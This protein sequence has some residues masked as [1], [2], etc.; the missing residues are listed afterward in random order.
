M[1]TAVPASYPDLFR[2]VAKT[3]ANREAILTP[4]ESVTYSEL[5]QLSDRLAS[6]LGPHIANRPVLTFF[7]RS[8]ECYIS[9]IAI[10]KAGGF[11]VPVNGNDP[12]ERI[13][14]IV[15]DS[16]AV[17][18][19]TG[20]D[21][22]LPASGSLPIER[23]GLEQLRELPSAEPVQATP[24]GLDFAYMIYTSGS[25]GKPK[26]VPIHHSALLNHN[27]WCVNEFE[28]KETTRVMQISS[29]SFDFSIE[30]IFP[31][32]LAGGSLFVPSD[33]SLQD[34]ATF[35]RTVEQY[36]V[37]SLS[38][39]TAF[40]HE[41]VIALDT[42]PFPRCVNDVG[43]GGE[44]VNPR[45]VQQWFERVA[46]ETLL[47][48]GYGPTE[49][50]ITASFTYLTPG[51]PI[52]IGRPIDGLNFE[53]WDRELNPL[54][55]GIEGEL[56]ISGAGVAQGYWRRPE[57]SKEKFIARDGKRFYRTGDLAVRRPDGQFE[58]KG[59]I[60]DQI[61]FR[62]YRIEFGEIID[63]MNSHPGVQQATIQVVHNDES[64]E[65][66]AYYRESG[67][68]GLAAE[69]LKD[70]LSKK[71]PAYMI[72]SLLIPVAKFPRTSGGKIDFKRLYRD[73][74]LRASSL[75]AE[76]MTDT[77]NR[78]AAIWR[79]LIHSREIRPDIDF[80]DA[81]GDSLS[82]MRMLALVE[83]Q[84]KGVPISASILATHSTIGDLARYLD[85]EAPSQP[86]DRNSSLFLTRISKLLPSPLKELTQPKN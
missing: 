71:L 21:R 16:Q 30:E 37:T 62:G 49:T 27:L 45:L 32:F 81:G 20:L 76:P 77:E 18:A 6:H 68:Q 47:I 26:G 17:I 3:F 11:F 60:D 75:P 1:Q 69:A 86:A 41:M 10:M 73:E 48:N 42:Y 8:P 63:A 12:R 36:Q 28:M 59:R 72:P 67:N 54:G 46:P 35:L 61:K 24:R 23:I 9:Q 57:L 51:Q 22:D 65:L 78:L 64:S 38:L 7:D 2:P 85:R 79:K 5:D 43:I 19:L 84:W 50:T 53:I 39:P 80:F 58:F 82:A 74:A 44:L 34:A 25:S 83:K 56:V 15:E 4:T 33:E 14:T 13:N 40:W 31:T 70:F 29:V 66:I 52:T 55:D